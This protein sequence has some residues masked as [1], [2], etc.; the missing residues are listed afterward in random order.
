MLSMRQNGRNLVD[1]IFKAI[2]FLIQIELKFVPGVSI[3]KKSA[4]VQAS[5]TEQAQAIN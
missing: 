3:D 1:D 4:L 5:G 2:I